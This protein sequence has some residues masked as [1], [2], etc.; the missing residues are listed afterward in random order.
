VVVWNCSI[1]YAIRAEER[2]ER[3]GNLLGK[4]KTSSL[5]AV[6]DQLEVCDG[7][8][9]E[10]AVSPV[11]PA[12]FSGQ[13]PNNEQQM[14]CHSQALIIQQTSNLTGEDEECWGRWSREM[15]SRDGAE[16]W[17]LR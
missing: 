10:T 1:V 3:S 8:C 12:R 13:R 14:D 6:V 4:R 9:L 2:T 15:E 11:S 5:D 7:R 16:R 17:G